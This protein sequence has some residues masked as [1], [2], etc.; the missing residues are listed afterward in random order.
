MITFSFQISESRFINEWAEAFCEWLN[1][2]SKCMANNGDTV[3]DVDEFILEQFSQFIDTRFIWHEDQW[4]L[5]QEYY[6]PQEL[7]EDALNNAYMMLEQE[8]TSLIEWTDGD[9]ER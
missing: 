9:S 7:N 4:Q 6:T 3:E 5:L 2:A 8:I 1:E